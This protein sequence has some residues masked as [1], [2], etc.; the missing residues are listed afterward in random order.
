MLFQVL[1][2]LLLQFTLPFNRKFITA[3]VCNVNIINII[4]DLIIQR[5]QIIA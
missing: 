1:I 3:V 2:A 5:Y 4:L